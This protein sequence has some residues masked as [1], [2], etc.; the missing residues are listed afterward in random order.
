MTD[1]L[2]D[3]I[4]AVLSD[5]FD[6]GHYCSCGEPDDGGDW[7]HEGHVAAVLIEALGMTKEDEYDPYDPFPPPYRI[8]YVTEWTTDD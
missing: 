2:R 4:A 7:G 5:H 6:G 1:N 8:R 3:R